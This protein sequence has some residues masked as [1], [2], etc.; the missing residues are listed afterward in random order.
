MKSVVVEGPTVAKAI[1]SAWLKAGKPEEFFIRILQE[2]TSGF[3][4]FGA[5]KAK[6]V[7]FF[8]NTNKSDSIF[9]TVLKQKEYTNFFGNK[10]LKNPTK[11]DVVDL[12]LNKNAVI[13]S[14]GHKK[15]PHH[16]QQKNQ[17]IKSNVQAQGKPAL[18]TPV[19]QIQLQKVATHNHAQGQQAKQG[20]IQAK[21]QHAHQLEKHGEQK[22]AM[23]VSLQAPSK[24]VEQKK[25]AIQTAH[26]KENI[27][28]NIAKVLKKVQSQ[29]IVANVSRPASVPL[30]QADK[31][32]LKKHHVEKPKVVTPKFESYAEF[33]DAQVDKAAAKVQSNLD[34]VEKISTSAQ[35]M[36]DKEKEIIKPVD[37]IVTKIESLHLDV[38]ASKPVALVVHDQSTVEKSSVQKRPFIKMKRRPLV[39]DNPGVSGIT[40]S[41]DKKQSD[42][43]VEKAEHD[44]PQK[45]DNE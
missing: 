35:A 18:D 23:Q 25:V 13:G 33:M 1:E 34:F 2:H 15:N 3:L 28:G 36:A 41:E 42:S 5:K 45:N 43:F 31:V 19:K 16:N 30:T 21:P 9:P 17:S 24:Q 6:I 4:G 11:L 8:K 32:S 44:Q 26:T 27:V 22:V 37:S 20:K 38:V 40:R 12:E 29:K 14:G 39:T 7:L 10:N